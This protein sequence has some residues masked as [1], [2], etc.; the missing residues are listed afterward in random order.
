[1]YCGNC[2]TELLEGDVFCPNCGAGAQ[3]AAVTQYTELEPTPTHCEHCG[4]ELSDDDV[5]CLNCGVGVQGIAATNKAEPKPASKYCENCGAEMLDDDVFCANCGATMEAPGISRTGTFQPQPTYA[6]HT[7]P[8]AIPPAPSPEKKDNTLKIVLGITIP[9][10]VLLLVVVLFFLPIGKDGAP[11]INF[12]KSASEASSESSS[13]PDTKDHESDV[14]AYTPQNDPPDTS[15][16]DEPE[17]SQDEPPEDSDTTPPYAG[18]RFVTN[19]MKDGIFIRSDPSVQGNSRKLRD[20]NKIGY[21]EDGDT[22]VELIATGA[23]YY[24]DDDGYWWYEV[25]I[26]EWYRN[27]ELQQQHYSDKPL[28]GWVRDDVVMGVS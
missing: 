16:Y 27:T 26:P 14:P 20:T 19:Q 8:V 28:I 6:K 7:P 23:E 13:P 12:Q 22:G 18:N 4:A 25:E 15:P 1:M 10:F 11:I 3:S 21:I 9:A 5:F 2:G 17:T 24:N